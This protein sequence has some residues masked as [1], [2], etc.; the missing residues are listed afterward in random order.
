MHIISSFFLMLLLGVASVQDIK[1]R[2]IPNKLNLAGFACGILCSIFDNTFAV[3]EA[4]LGAAVALCIG[5][6]CWFLKVFRAGDAKLLCAVGAFVGWKMSINVFLFSLLAGVVAGLPY[7][8]FRLVRK[9]KGL[10]KFPFAT[11]IMAGTI[12]GMHAGYLWEII[13]LI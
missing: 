12:V 6:V 11:A 5:V 3:S 1:Q 9:E 13:K 10:T 2:K 4:I 8:I 7:V